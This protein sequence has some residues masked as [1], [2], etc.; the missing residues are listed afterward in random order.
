MIACYLYPI[1][2]SL[3]LLI[4]DVLNRPSHWLAFDLADVYMFFL[5]KMVLMGLYNGSSNSAI[6]PP[7]DS[8][9][10]AT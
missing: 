3:V 2:F 4:V 6:P 10:M 1:S 8:G 7:Q 5:Q 9:I